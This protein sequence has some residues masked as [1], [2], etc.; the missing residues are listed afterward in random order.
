MA[1]NSGDEERTHLFSVQFAAR[2]FANFGGALTESS[3][4][5]VSGAAME[6]CI[7]ERWRLSKTLTPVSGTR[8]IRKGDMVLNGMTPDIAVDPETY[9]VRANGELLVCEPATVLPMA[10]RYFLF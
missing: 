8:S 5:F 3:L 1:A 9:E 6:Q 10:Q 4:T 7:G 2:M